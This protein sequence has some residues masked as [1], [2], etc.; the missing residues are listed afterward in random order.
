MPGNLLQKWVENASTVLAA[1]AGLDRLQEL[2][3][4]ADL[5]VGDFDSARSVA[6]LPMGV[7]RH[8]P[9]QDATDCDKLLE[10]AAEEGFE[11]ITL[12]S[13]EGDQLDH[14][15]ATLHS[16]ARSPLRVRLG[17]RKG[18][19]W[20]LS[21]GEEVVMRTLPGRRISLLPLEDAQGVTLSGVEWP[22]ENAILH[23]L[24]QTSISNR[25]AA[26]AVTAS[27]KTGSAFL[28]AEYPPEEM[29]FW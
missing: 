7:A 18:V 10:V 27:I 4:L 15:L 13:V 19:G 24:K 26:A 2:G 1:D 12:V 22:L 20:I 21:A 8:R 16:A 6:D 9:D 23:P 3:L 29:P 11:R 25:A 17:L 28:F 5:V 14:M